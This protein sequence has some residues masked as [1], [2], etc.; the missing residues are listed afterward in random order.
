[1]KTILMKQLPTELNTLVKR[2]KV[3][4]AKLERNFINN[5]AFKIKKAEDQLI[6]NIFEQ[7]VVSFT[8]KA[9]RVQMARQATLEAM[10]Y[11]QPSRSHY[12][13]LEQFG[14][15]RHPSAKRSGSGRNIIAPAPRV[16]KNV[17]NQFGNIPRRL[18]KRKLADSSKYFVGTP[19]RGYAK[20]IYQRMKRSRRGGK[21]G[22]LKPIVFFPKAAKYPKKF[23]FYSTAQKVMKNKRMN[24]DLIN[25]GYIYFSNL[26]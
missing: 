13:N 1:M 6:L 8:R 7:P 16:S 20:G 4:G 22:G 14:G 11:V 12:F 17:L 26:I 21:S 3:Q 10:V 2:V 9:I 18:V 24:Y 5:A 19:H 25:M 23:M 15:T